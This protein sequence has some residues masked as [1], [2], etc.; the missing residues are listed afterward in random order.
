ML[1]TIVLTDIQVI[2]SQFKMI[3]NYK[4]RWVRQIDPNDSAI[5]NDMKSEL[6]YNIKR[7]ALYKLFHKLPDKCTDKFSQLFADVDIWKAGST[8]YEL[9]SLIVHCNGNHYVAY[10]KGN[11]QQ[12][13]AD[14]KYDVQSGVSQDI[15]S[16]GPPPTGVSTLPSVSSNDPFSN[17]PSF[18]SH[19]GPSA[20]PDNELRSMGIPDVSTSVKRLHQIHGTASTMTR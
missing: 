13:G 20:T 6:E 2:F 15:Q 14:A 17:K 3:N 5:Q 7:T 8:T 18:G 11:V 19:V 10:I 1:F 12:E 9:A 4:A 16:A